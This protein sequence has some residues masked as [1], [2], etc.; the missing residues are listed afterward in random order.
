MH[1]GLIPC[2]AE[3]FKC[4][5]G[6]WQ[7]KTNFRRQVGKLESHSEDPDVI[8]ILWRPQLQTYWRKNERTGSHD[9]YNDCYSDQASLSD[10]AAVCVVGISLGG[11]RFTSREICFMKQYTRTKWIENKTLSD[12]F[13][14]VFLSSLTLIL[15]MWRIW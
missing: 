1:L 2:R 13:S 9:H 12:W 10:A 3:L 5:R 8:S 7:L 4:N 6:T 14:P 15:L 11:F